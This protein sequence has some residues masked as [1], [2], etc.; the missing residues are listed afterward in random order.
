MKVRVPN[1]RVFGVI[2]EGRVGGR[3]Y[4][5][6]EGVTLLSDGGLLLQLTH[7]GRPGQLRQLP[8]F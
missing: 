5:Q 8:H 7:R 4:V 6:G 2:E 1:M 3:D